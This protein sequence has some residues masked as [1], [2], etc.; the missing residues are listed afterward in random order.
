MLC[1]S[2]MFSVRR[3]WPLV[4]FA[5]AAACS[6][7]DSAPTPDVVLKPNV[8]ILDAASLARIES[9][10]PDGTIAFKEHDAEIDALAVG[11]VVA[12]GIATAVPRG[13]LRR[14]TRVDQTADRVVVATTSAVLTDAIARGQLHIVRPL[15]IADVQPST[16]DVS[17]MGFYVGLDDVVLYEESG[18]VNAKLTASGSISVEPVLGLGL[19]FFL[20][21]ATDA[22]KDVEGRG[23]ALFTDG[24]F[25]FGGQTNAFGDMDLIA[26]HVTHDGKL[27]FAPGSG[28]TFATLSGSSEAP[29][30]APAVTT[31]TGVATYAVT[32]AVFPITP[33][34]LDAKPTKLT[35]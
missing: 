30:P 16:I 3:A 34:A 32:P 15:V 13:L 11:D 2:F 7:S 31:S 8:H 22:T 25:A 23:L 17:L 27:D 6:S 4:V 5:A 33:T 29:Y 19:E 26:L 10:S 24:S 1:I 21:G 35:Q 18:N 9:I 12:G 14:V 20:D 28:M